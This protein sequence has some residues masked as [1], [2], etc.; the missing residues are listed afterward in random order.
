M[1]AAPGSSPP[2]T[3]AD[4]SH[5]FTAKAMDAA[6]NVSAASAALNV[7]VDTVAP[8][9][10]TIISD[11]PASAT[12]LIV[13]G[14]AEAGSTVKLFDGSTFLGIAIA[15]PSGTWNISTGSLSQGTHNFTATATDAAGNVSDISNVLDPVIGTVIEAAG[16]SSLVEVGTNFYLDSISTGS[17]PELK[18]GGK[19]V[20][21]GQ[22]SGWTPIG[23]EQT[24]TGYE[25][26]WKV[27]GSDQVFGLDHR[28]SRQLRWKHRRNVRHQRRP[29]IVG[30]QLPSG[31]EWQWRNR[32]PRP[33]HDGDR[34][35]WIDQP[36]RGWH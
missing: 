27:T 28:Q 22:F 34:G 10:P 3:L 12:A 31:P 30:D 24:A 7:T 26:A 13:N 16:S 32:Y 33:S 15:N 2:R 18:Y 23:A 5:A 17:G 9:A 6:G 14:T 20:V 35:A 36:D 4:G 19:A 29:G 25:V 11:A 1:A 21:A 8:N